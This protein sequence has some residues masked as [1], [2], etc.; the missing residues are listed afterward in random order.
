MSATRAASGQKFECC[1]KVAAEHRDELAPFSFD[2]LV[3]AGE[4][5]PMDLAALGLMTKSN[6]VGC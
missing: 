6:F 3:G 5:R 2:H 1:S 4:P